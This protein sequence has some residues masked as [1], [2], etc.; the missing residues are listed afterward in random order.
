[1]YAMGLNKFN[2][3]KVVSSDEFDTLFNYCWTQYL[4]HEHLD[5]PPQCQTRWAAARRRQSG[6]ITAISKR[7][8]GEPV[9]PSNTLKI[10]RFNLLTLIQPDKVPRKRQRFEEGSPLSSL[11]LGWIP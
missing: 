6:D 8:P 10:R 1:V 4:P 2:K 5:F 9:T 11:L 7:P 3:K